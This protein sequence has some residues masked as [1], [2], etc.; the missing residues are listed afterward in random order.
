[1][2]AN[3]C[4]KQSDFVFKGLLVATIFC[5]FNG[6]VRVQPSEMTFF[7]FMFKEF[8][9]SDNILFSESKDQRFLTWRMSHYLKCRTALTSPT[10]K[11]PVQ[12]RSTAIMRH[13][14]AFLHDITSSADNTLTACA[15]NG[16]ADM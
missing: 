15:C 6:E 11:K 8:Q 7:L 1:M 12:F 10:Q 3:R 4:D 2:Q 13:A 9:R 16:L 14:N 5:F